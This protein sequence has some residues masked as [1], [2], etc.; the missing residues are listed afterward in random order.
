MLDHKTAYKQSFPDLLGNNSFFNFIWMEVILESKGW[1][2]PYAHAHTGLGG[3]AIFKHY[4]GS[5][6]SVIAIRKVTY[7]T[8]SERSDCLLT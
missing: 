2:R 6:P 5:V 3:P 7:H 1:K 8:Q 4:T